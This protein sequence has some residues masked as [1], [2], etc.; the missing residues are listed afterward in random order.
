VGLVKALAF[1]PV[2]RV[3]EGYE[4][5]TTHAVYDAVLER[6]GQLQLL[7]EVNA[8]DRYLSR[9]YLN[10][11]K[12]PAWNCFDRGRKRSNNDHEGKNNQL[13]QAIDGKNFW[14]F[15]KSILQYLE[16]ERLELD[17]MQN[18]GAF[19]PQRLKWK[20]LDRTIEQ[21]IH[22]FTQNP[23]NHNNNTVLQYLG[24]HQN[25]HT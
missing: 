5:I 20:R 13:A 21:H 6:A 4:M 14:S 23:E 2:H 17:Q 16:K 3:L 25:M 19:P 12:I 8:F 22:N 15:M 7:R 9:N 11:L 10:E 24:Y 1:L 18:G